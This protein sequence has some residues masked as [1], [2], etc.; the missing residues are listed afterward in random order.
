[1][2]VHDRPRA[3]SVVLYDSSGIFVEPGPLGYNLI[4][5]GFGAACYLAAGIV[6]HRRDLPAPL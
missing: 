2:A 3:W 5:L 1:M 6:F 4:L